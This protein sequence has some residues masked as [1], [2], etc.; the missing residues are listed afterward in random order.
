VR[1]V[2]QAFSLGGEGTKRLP[3][4]GH[5]LCCI[6]APP[7]LMQ[8]VYEV[9]PW[10]H[11]A[12]LILQGCSGFK[13]QRVDDGLCGR[14]R[15]GS[16]AERCDSD[17]L[18]QGPCLYSAFWASYVLQILLHTD[19]LHHSHAILRVAS[20]KLILGQQPWAFPNCH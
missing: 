9:L 7:F 17:V 6:D 11:F 14:G 15:V 20:I 5:M 13:I 19:S 2:R 1:S 16:T 12:L 8:T 10:F 4:E 18:G 3:H